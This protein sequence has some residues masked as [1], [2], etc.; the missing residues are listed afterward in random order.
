MRT[1]LVVDDEP[2]VR[3]LLADFFGSHGYEIVGAGDGQA[4]IDLLKQR[5]FDLFFVD[6]TMPGMGGIDVL[7]E[8]KALDIRIPSIVITGFGSIPSAVEAVRLGAYD[9][10]TKPFNLDDLMITV[11]RV[12]DLMKLQKE[13][14]VLK[15]QIKEKYNFK[16]LIGN[17]RQMQDLHRFIGKITDTDATVLIT[18]ESGTGKELVAKTIHFNSSR[19]GE[20]FVP[21]N[22]GAIPRD[23]IESELFGH[24]KGAFTGAINSR[25]GRFELANGGTIFLDEI[26]ELPFPLQ[27]KLLRVIQEREFERVGGTR[28]IKVDVRILAATNRDLEKAVAEHTFREDLF[29]RLNVIPVHIPPLRERDDD[30]LLLVSHFIEEFCRRKRKPLVKVSREAGDILR[31][32][33]WPG[34][35]REVMNVVERMIILNESGEIGV[36]DLPQRIM[37]SRG[38]GAKLHPVSAVA[39]PADVPVPAQWTEAGVDLNGILEEMEK[40]LI[41]QALSKSGGVKNKAATLLG[42]NRTTFLEKVKKMGV[43]APTSGS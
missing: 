11:N 22:C 6:L 25:V 8:V 18:G 24:E 3:N 23:L 20:P 17:S 13:N 15:K 2:L 19:M 28:T 14:T 31:N 37:E 39:P 30:V 42:L 29:Y 7:R 27:V 41:V 43:S 33:G 21:L 35:V 34:N 9:Y 36:E 32:Y 12:F 26:G 38:N 5:K 10:I 4:G 40:K 16:K 1:I